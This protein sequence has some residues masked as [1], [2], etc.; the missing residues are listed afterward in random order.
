M[1]AQGFFSFSFFF[2]FSLSLSFPN[3]FFFFLKVGEDKARTRLPGK[4][5]EVA[6][7]GNT[8]QFHLIKHE[9]RW[10]DLEVGWVKAN[11]EGSAASSYEVLPINPL[12]TLD[13]HSTRR[14]GF[15]SSFLIH[16]LFLF[17]FVCFVLFCSVYFFF[18][19]LTKALSTK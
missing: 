1:V 2:L 7:G 17:L 10:N 14:D 19:L 4:G 15:P 6:E 5:K 16:F 18:F 8:S 13:L 9:Q 12:G 3:L 11:S